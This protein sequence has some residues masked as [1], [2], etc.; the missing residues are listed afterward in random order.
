MLEQTRHVSTIAM[1]KYSRGGGVCE[2]VWC[3]AIFV[4]LYNT[5]SD[6]NRQIS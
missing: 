2:G 4:V 6:E 5:F 3:E 1:Q